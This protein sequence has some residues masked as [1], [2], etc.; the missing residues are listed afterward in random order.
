MIERWVYI[1][2]VPTPLLDDPEFWEWISEPDENED[3]MNEKKLSDEELRVIRFAIENSADATPEEGK[4][5]DHIEA[6]EKENSNLKAELAFNSKEH[7]ERIN[8]M[9]ALV[10]PDDP[11]GWEYWGQVWRHVRDQRDEMRQRIAEQTEQIQKLEQARV[12]LID[13]VIS[14]A[15]LGTSA[16]ATILALINRIKELEAALKFYADEKNYALPLNTVW[17]NPVDVERGHRAR[18]VLKANG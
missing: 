1:V 3:E 4:L 7:T 16:E 11:T 15:E 14:A 13:N 2:A 6:M 17:E 12:G 8:E 18:E 10:Y 5:L 9:W